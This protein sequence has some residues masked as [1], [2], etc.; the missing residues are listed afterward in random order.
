MTSLPV[1]SLDLKRP[2]LF[3]SP[4]DPCTY[5]MSK[6]RLTGWRMKEIVLDE[7]ILDQ[8]VPADQRWMS[9]PRKDHKNFAAEF[10][11]PDPNYQPTEL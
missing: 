10:F 7:A 8:S 9:G 5:D 1:L 3:Y 11:E 6:P 2:C 4:L